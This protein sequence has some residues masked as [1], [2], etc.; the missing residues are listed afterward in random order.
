M[1]LEVNDGNASALQF[2]DL[3][4]EVS[5][6]SELDGSELT[7]RLTAYMKSNGLSFDTLQQYFPY[8]PDR[9]YRNMYEVGLLNGVAT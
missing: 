9:I 8:Y 3:I 7:E 5:D 6:I 1:K 2:L 4:K